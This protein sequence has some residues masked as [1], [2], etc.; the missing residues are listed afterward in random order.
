MRRKNAYD[1][2]MDRFEGM[3]NADLEQEVDDMEGQARKRKRAKGQL[4]PGSDSA[5]VE[6]DRMANPGREA[7]LRNQGGNV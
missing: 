6:T 3:V 4:D 5:G 1:I 2:Q 7:L